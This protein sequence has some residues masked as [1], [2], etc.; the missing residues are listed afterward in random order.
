[1]LMTS[2]PPVARFRCR[3]GIGVARMCALTAGLRPRAP[4][5]KCRSGASKASRKRRCAHRRQR[6]SCGACDDR[7]RSTSAA[8][9]RIGVVKYPLMSAAAR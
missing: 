1:M 7:V 3:S 6:L 9:R 4:S 2:L 5:S 8:F